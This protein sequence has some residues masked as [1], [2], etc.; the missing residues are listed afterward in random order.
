MPRHI[1][2]QACT[3]RQYRLARRPGARDLMQCPRT[4]LHKPLQGVCLD[5]IRMCVPA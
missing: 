4:E 5:L 2:I 3:R 1:E